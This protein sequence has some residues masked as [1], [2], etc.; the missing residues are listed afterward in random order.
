MRTFAQKRS[1]K[2][3][4]SNPARSHTVTPRLHHRTDLIQNLQRPVGN[5]ALPRL[6]QSNA[7]ERNAIFTGIALP[8]F[9]HDFARIPVTS[10]NAVA[11]QTKLAINKPGDDHE[12]EADRMAEQVMRMPE[13]QLQRAC[14]CGAGCSKCHTNQPGQ[15]HESLQTKRVQASETVQVAAPPIVHEI[16]GSPGQPLD[17]ATRA[18]FEPRFRQDFSRVRVH[19]NLQAAAAAESVRAHAFTVGHNLVFGTGRFAP[20]SSEGQNLL[21]HELTHVV[22][23]EGS[24]APVLQRDDKK[25]TPPTMKPAPVPQEEVPADTLSLIQVRWAKLKGAVAKFPLLMEWIG[26]GDAVI[27]LMLDHE[28]GYYR[29]IEAG[30]AQLADFYKLLLQGDL[31]AYNYVS[32]HAYVYRN[33]LRLQA[34]FDSLMRSF[35]ADKR[36]FTGKHDAEEKVRVIKKLIDSV[37]NQSANTLGDLVVD[38]P[39]TFRSG[40]VITITS[41]ADKQKRAALQQETEKLRKTDLA[42]AIIIDEINTFLWSATKEGFWQAVEAVKEYYEVRQGI[43]D[44]GG[45]P[46]ADDKSNQPSSQNQNGSGAGNGSGSGSQTEKEKKPEKQKKPGEPCDVPLPIEWPNKLPLPA[47]RRPLERTPSGDWNLAPEKRSA[48]QRNLHDAIVEARSKNVLPPRLCFKDVEPNTPFDAHHI[49]PL[50]LGGAEDKVNLCSLFIDNHQIGHRQLFD[51]SNMVRS[52][53]VWNACK[54]TK[55]NLKDHPGGQE[56]AIRGRK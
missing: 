53:P 18:Y 13:P 24:A 54:I 26:K 5:Q 47:A 50:F 36:D 56:Y 33:W 11:L 41:A 9:G 7:E 3:V 19:S 1:Q 49:Q 35:D 2:P 37:G 30:D 40:V 44:D 16:L 17:P 25:G 4:Y 48:P 51:Q 55:S 27:A 23:Q 34:R 31:V 38:R 21:A 20:A 42:V 45:G 39:Y 29:A 46:D 15:E 10:P 12:Q 43:L 8:H 32:W 28:F 6:L 22:Q 52:D 14:F